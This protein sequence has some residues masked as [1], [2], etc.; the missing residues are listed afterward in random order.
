MVFCYGSPNRVREQ[1]KLLSGEQGRR[2][3]C[4][5]KIHYLKTIIKAFIFGQFIFTWSQSSD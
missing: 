3:D 2:D 5:R 4:G 1:E